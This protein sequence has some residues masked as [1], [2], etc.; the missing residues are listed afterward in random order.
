MVNQEIID[1]YV[2]HEELKRIKLLGQ[3]LFFF[4]LGLISILSI[5]KIAFF[6]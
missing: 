4:V 1:D 3:K 2:T 6:A 5:L